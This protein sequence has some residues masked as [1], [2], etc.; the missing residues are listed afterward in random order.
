MKEVKAF[1][2]ASI[3]ESIEYIFNI[4]LIV[5]FFKCFFK[6]IEP[7]QYFKIDFMYLLSQRKNK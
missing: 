6:N 7:T 4:K 3:Y 5:V 1:S 2:I